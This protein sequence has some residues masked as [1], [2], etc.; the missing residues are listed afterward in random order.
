MS[1][2]EL[3]LERIYVRDASFE[4]PHAPD[5]F[6]EQW[7]PNIQLEINTRANGLGEERYEVVLTA[8]VSAKSDAGKTLLIVEVQ[9]A[10]IFRVRGLAEDGL[11]RL[12]ATQCPTIL[13]PYI[14]ET[15]DSLMAR[16]GFPPLHLAPVNFDAMFAEAL[17]RRGAPPEVQH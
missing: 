7:Q 4:S 12:L 17:K 10:G 14:R 15:V 13:F 1:E 16:G 5:V 3:N 9:Q 8:T 6:R 2:A 11:R